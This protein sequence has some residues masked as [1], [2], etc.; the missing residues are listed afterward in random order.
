MMGVSAKNLLIGCDVT[1][2]CHSYNT[3]QKSDEALVSGSKSIWVILFQSYSSLLLTRPQHTQGQDF[4]Q[5]ISLGSKVL[6]KSLVF[7][8]RPAAFDDKG[9]WQPLPQRMATEGN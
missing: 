9:K 5:K 2:I 8:I 1:F 4:G 3:S 6:V 7:L